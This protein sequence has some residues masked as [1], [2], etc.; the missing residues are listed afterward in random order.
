MGD[1]YL[2]SLLVVG[3][4]SPVRQ[5]KEAAKTNAI[6][7]AKNVFLEFFLFALIVVAVRLVKLST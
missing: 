4:T 2:R 7:S 6:S 3:M 1:Q 5:T